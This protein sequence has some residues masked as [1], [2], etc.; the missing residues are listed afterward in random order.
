MDTISKY[1]DYCCLTTAPKGDFN[2]FIRI[3]GGVLRGFVREW[4]G[5]VF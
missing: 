2:I 3:N 1:M 5:G 4:F